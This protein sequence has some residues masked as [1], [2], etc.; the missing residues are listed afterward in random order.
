MNILGVFN[1]MMMGGREMNI[2]RGLLFAIALGLTVMALMIYNPG[3]M[4]I[5]EYRLKGYE[6]QNTRHFTLVY[7]ADSREDIYVVVKAAEYAYAAVNEDFDY[8]PPGRIPI[9]IFPDSQSLQGAFNWP[10]N[11]NN[12]GV[13]HRDVI[14]IQSPS[15]WVPENQNLE[16]EFLLKG[17]MVHEYTHLVVDH[18]TVG[19][20]PRWFTE[21]VAQY[22][23]KRVTGYTLEQDFSIDKSF[24]YSQ[25]DIFADFDSLPDVSRAYIQALE[26]TTQLV[27]EGGLDTLREILPLLRAGAS[28]NEL[29]LQRVG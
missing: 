14:Y 19:N 12:Q 25:Q 29:F 11:E 8:Y 20:Y 10:R 23:E 5:L 6:V 22:E 1:I 17:P 13:Y 7:Q 28:A 18:L 26:M 21:G 16:K 15:A 27:G 3:Q 24:Y 2:R 4:K 9:I